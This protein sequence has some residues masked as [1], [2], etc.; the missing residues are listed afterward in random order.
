M[1]DEHMGMSTHVVGFRP[2]DEKWKK[3]KAVWDACEAAGTDIPK[4][5]E[6]F[7][8]GESPDDQG[9]AIDIKDHACCESY[10]GDGSQGFEIDLKKLPPD[11][12]IIRFYNSY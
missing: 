5:V 10:D 9:V 3:M 7:F 6:R 1:E 11:V 4:D 2:P 8:N 12:T